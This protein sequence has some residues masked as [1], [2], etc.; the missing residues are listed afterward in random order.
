MNLFHSI[1]LGF[2]ISLGISYGLSTW[3]NSEVE[4]AVLAERERLTFQYDKKVTESIVQSMQASAKLQDNFDKAMKVKDAKITSTNTRYNALVASLQQRPSRPSSPSNANS[5]SDTEGTTGATGA[6]LYREDAS[7]LARF[8]RDA[9]QL[10]VELLQCYEQYDTVRE[11]V[12]K[13]G[14]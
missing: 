13:F 7:A 10:K 4:A 5:T 11:A 3:K 12:N 14:K 1:V 2:V 8:A 6:G 9:E